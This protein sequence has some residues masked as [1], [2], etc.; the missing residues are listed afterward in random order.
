MLVFIGTKFLAKLV[1]RETLEMN[2]EVEPHKENEN[3]TKNQMGMDNVGEVS[4]EDAKISS[5]NN[6]NFQVVIS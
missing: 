6:F 2:K 1:F 4:A 3:V 5:Y